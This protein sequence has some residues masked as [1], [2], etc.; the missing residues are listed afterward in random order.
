MNLP[1][2]ARG[3]S[4]IETAISLVIFAILVGAAV[5]SLAGMVRDNRVRSL[6]DEFSDGL[7]FAR[8]EALTRNR[9]IRF[10]FDTSGWRVVLPGA[11]PGQDETLAT[12]TRTSSESTYRITASATTVTFSGN[13]RASP[14]NF[15][16]DVGH[17][18]QA[19]RAAGG[20][21]RCLRIRV[22][23][24]GAIRSCDTAVGEDDPRNCG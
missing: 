17:A 21:V 1:H 9:Q 12:R 11:T 19:C 24:G 16:A 14:G 4:M 6:A 18:S 3:F 8:Q 20:D 10:T 2:H 5:P 15:S 23:A 7:Q 22:A 13:G